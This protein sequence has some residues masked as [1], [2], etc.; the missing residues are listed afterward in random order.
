MR[1]NTKISLD[2]QEATAPENEWGT[3][4]GSGAKR[5][6]PMQGG[7]PEPVEDRGGSGQGHNN[8]ATI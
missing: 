8:I 7:G 2:G 1:G 3:T 6:A 4:I 5:G